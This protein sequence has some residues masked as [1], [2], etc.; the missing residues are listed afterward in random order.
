MAYEAVVIIERDSGHDFAADGSLPD[1]L[2]VDLREPGS[3]T[4]AE[5]CARQLDRVADLPASSSVRQTVE[6]AVDQI[7]TLH[8]VDQ[9]DIAAERS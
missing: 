4:A 7:K 3:D 5:W 2:I 9:A 6:Q 1:I 8:N